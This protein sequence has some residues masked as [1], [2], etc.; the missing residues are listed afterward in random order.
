MAGINGTQDKTRRGQLEKG[1]YPLAMVQRSLHVNCLLAVWY[2]LHSRGRII[3][4]LM[5]VYQEDLIGWV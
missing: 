3:S 5:G 2:I 4:Y 1:T